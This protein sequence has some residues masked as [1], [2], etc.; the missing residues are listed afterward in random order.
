MSTYLFWV[1][2]TFIGLS[3]TQDFCPGFRQSVVIP[4]DYDKNVPDALETGNVTKVY[5][6]FIVRQVYGVKEDR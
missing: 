3:K 6:F 4:T 5:I 2:L 1:L